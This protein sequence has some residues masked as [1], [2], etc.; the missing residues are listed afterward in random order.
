MA[1]KS[2]KC[3]SCGEVFNVPIKLILLQSGE[4]EQEGFQDVEDCPFCNPEKYYDSE[5]KD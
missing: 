2:F 4:G 3:F 5:V 1:L